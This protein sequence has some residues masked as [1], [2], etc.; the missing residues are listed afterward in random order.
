MI[1]CLAIATPELGDRS[2]LLHDGDAAAV[3]D[4][5]RDI[6]RIIA[7]TADLGLRITCVAETHIHNDYVSGGRAL[8][9][10]LDVP[11]LVAAGE[12]VDFR[13]VAVRDGDEIAVGRSFRLR[14][15][16]TPGHTLHHVA[17]VALDAGRPVMVCSGG[18]LLYGTTG[19]TDLMGSPW[20]APLTRAQ[21]RSAQRLA[22]L[23]DQVEL[24]PTHGFGS[25]CAAGPG[26]GTTPDSTASSTIGEQRS[27]NIALRVADEEAFVPTL[28]AG[29][30]AYPSYYAHTGDRNRKGAPRLQLEPLPELSGAAVRDLILEGGWAV[31][32]RPRQSFATAHLAGSVNIEH[33]TMFSTYLGWVMPWGTPLALLA[34]D[35]ATI[36]AAQ[37]DLA[38]IGIDELAGQ[39][40]GPTRLGSRGLRVE[41]YPVAERS[42]LLAARQVPGTLVLDVRRPDE[43]EQ[44]HIDG[45]WHIALPELLGRVGDLPAGVVWV[46]CA[47]GYRAAIAASLL[48]RAGRRVVLVDGAVAT[49]RAA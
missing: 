21:F 36:A 3:I 40:I 12:D 14:V 26:G 45:A 41:R 2:Y 44:D 30:A 46:Y 43:W 11:Y 9:E 38:R 47:A 49:A 37:R 33:A 4:P 24:W 32:L 22:G 6:D 8:A 28:L 23:G 42:E 16:D 48:A 34:D 35:A 1:R 31:D 25:F 18:S 7:T 20:T 19:R 17:Y 10:L 39:A 5:Q 15:M 29:L 27:I 13:R